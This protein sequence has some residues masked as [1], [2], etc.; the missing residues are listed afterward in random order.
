MWSFIKGKQVD[1]KTRNLMVNGSFHYSIK[2]LKRKVS[3]STRHLCKV[4][5]YQANLAALAATYL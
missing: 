4:F 2:K 5:F 1:E 3:Q